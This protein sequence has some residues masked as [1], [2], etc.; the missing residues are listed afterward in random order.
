MKKKRA[1]QQAEIH[2]DSAV[3]R[4]N[5][6]HRQCHLSALLPFSEEV[7]GVRK[8]IDFRVYLEAAGY[9]ALRHFNERSPRV[10]LHLPERLKDCDVHLSIQMH[11]TRFSPIYAAQQ[12]QEILRVQNSL[13]TPASFALL[14][15]ARS[16]VSQTLSILAGVYELP[17]ISASSTSASL[18]NKDS[19]PFF[20]RTVPTNKNDAKATI[21]YLRSLGVT[22]LGIIYIRDDFGTQFNSH[23]LQEAS[24]NGIQVVSTSYGEDVGKQSIVTG[25]Q[26]L[27]Q[28][29]LR[30][31]MGIFNPSTWKDVVREASKQG[32]IGSPD[33]AWLLSDASLELT[34]PGFQL[35]RDTEADLA[36]A[37][38][39][40]G[41]VVINAESNANFDEALAELQTDPLLQQEFVNAHVESYIFEG[42]EFPF[43]G[44]ALYQYLNYDA[45]IALGLAACEAPQ[46]FFTGPEFYNT[47]VRTEFEGV[48]GLVRF[49]HDTGTRN[50]QGVKYRIENVRLAAKQSSNQTYGF[51]TATAAL[52]DFLESN[53]IQTESGFVY[54]GGSTVPPT[55]LPPLTVDLNL[56]GTG[57]RVTGLLLG[58][59]TM[60]CA[61]GWMIWTS[62][63]RNID[64]V[65]ISQPV[66]LCQLCVGTF[67]MASAII[68]MSMQ[69]PISQRG[70]N[71]ACMS[72]PW[73]LSLGFVTAF[74]ALF[75]KTW[76]LNKV[77][78]D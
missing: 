37:V 55:S 28:S 10:L 26:Q 74:S 13:S 27:Q 17:Q 64:C 69:E 65:R 21:L 52:V 72:T 25:I 77:R 42:Y 75:S 22:H 23:L 30:Y 54:A 6:T 7:Q 24:R 4:V 19:S 39:G 66:F 40:V 9:L 59:F 61:I 36:A 63:Y 20:A 78:V 29:G 51:N 53:P 5:A 34:Q 71:I 16:A 62:Y 8:P 14:G 33:Y 43:P 56:I 70:L 11:D 73:L 60:L 57:I 41:V 49:S 3:I 45:V 31:F 2:P 46:E 48:S 44:P 76:R 67:I 12:L 1:L 35:R 47:L 18:D 50:E 15:A 68:P 32:I 38:D 58:T